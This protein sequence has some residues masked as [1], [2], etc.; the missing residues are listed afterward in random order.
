MQRDWANGIVHMD[1]AFLS[2]S[3]PSL[4]LATSS[5]VKYSVQRWGW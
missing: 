2:E 1:L 4:Y 3:D 5:N